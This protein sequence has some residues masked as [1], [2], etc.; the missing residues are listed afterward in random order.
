M[1]WRDGMFLCKYIRNLPRS[2]GCLTVKCLTMNPCKH[3]FKREASDV[4]KQCD[5]NNYLGYHYFLSQCMLKC[6][7]SP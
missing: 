6:S 5:I 7:Y 4:T 3:P 1:S 2:S